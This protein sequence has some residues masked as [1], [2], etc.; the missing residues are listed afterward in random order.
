MRE[1]G[2]PPPEPCR[3]WYVSSHTVPLKALGAAEALAGPKEQSVGG[4]CLSEP[5]CRACGSHAGD[6]VLDL[7][8]QPAADWLPP[9][10]DLGPDP[11]YPLQMWLCASCGLAQLVAGPSTT[12][13]PQGIEP[14][15]VIAQAREAVR[16]V[17]AAGLLPHGGRVA[18]Y[19]SP[20]DGSWMDLLVPYG[21]SPAC[22]GAPAEVVLDCFGL[23][24]VADQAAAVAERAARVAP[25]GVLLVQYHSLE[26]IVSHG[27]WN[28]LRHGHYA[29]HSTTSLTKIL[30]ARGFCSLTGWRFDLFGGTVL[31]TAARVADGGRPGPSVEL[32]LR[33]D[34]RT[35]VRDATVLRGLQRQAE[36]HAA[37]LHEWLVAEQTA[38]RAVVGYGAASRAVP[39]LVFAGADRT[40][41]QAVADASV[42]KQGRRMPG[43]DI[44]IIAPSQIADHE[45]LSVL[46]LVPDLLSE[47]R[48]SLPGIE[49]S[50][51]RWV[52]VAVLGP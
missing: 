30:A 26:A 37:R 41:L 49:A 18:E 20:H 6:L 40:L 29:Y 31:L 47:V 22:E 2:R 13:E 48:A 24:H 5:A 50:G 34:E 33:Q 45:P 21:L 28:L 3:G 10:G 39:L 11:V 9:R 35:G 42:A 15:A 12:E 23:M 7:G 52:D 16:R 8:N 32:L 46:V 17:S 38:G 14:A 25:G 19:R 43:T 4:D 44:P 36:D 51:A 27:Q 1:I